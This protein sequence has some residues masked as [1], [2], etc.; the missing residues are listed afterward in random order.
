M[1]NKF[2]WLGSSVGTSERL[3]IVRSPVRSRPKPPVGLFGGVMQF[4]KVISLA[5]LKYKSMWKWALVGLLT[6][7]I[8]YLLFLAIYSFFSSVL[9]ANFF[10]GVISLSFNYSM[11]YFWSFKSKSEHKQSGFRFLVNF[12]IIWSL[13]TLLLKL[14]ITLGI[15]PHFAKIIP[16]LLSAPASFISMNYFVFQKTLKPL[17]R[18]VDKKA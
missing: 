6:A 14:L 7:L 12:V 3:K 18:S 17:N 1:I 9:I 15:Q 11:H 13:G 2:D 8:D 10:A 4:K 5:K 16:V